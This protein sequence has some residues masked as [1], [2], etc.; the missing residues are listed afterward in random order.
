MNNKSLALAT[1]ASLF[2]FLACSKEVDKK[3][4]LEELKKQLATLNTEIKV[5]EKELGGDLITNSK[6]KPVAVA[7]LSNQVYNHYLEVVGTVESDQNIMVSSLANGSIQTILV[8]E[9]DRVEKGQVMARIDGETLKKGIDELEVQ[10]GLATEIFNRQAKLWEEKVGTE[11]QYLQAKAGK[12]SLERRLATTKEQ[13]KAYFVKAPISGVVDEVMKKEGELATA[14][15]PFCRVVSMNTYKVT[16]DVAEAYLGK[17]KK[18]DVVE[19]SFPDLDSKSS[20]RIINAASV[21]N[22]INRSFSVEVK[23]DKNL[24]G[25]RPNMITVLKINDYSN[26]KAIVVPINVVQNS[27][28]GQFVFVTDNN[29][30]VIKKKVDIGQIYNS[31]A[32][33]KTGLVEGDMLITAGFNDLVEGEKVQF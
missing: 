12:E 28:D 33:I 19:V 18:G 27:P 17:V 16:G 22:P 30:L 26:K 29:K 8:K 13:Y 20:G 25:L 32:E 14:G 21:I 10:L 7:S 23:L 1:I 2:L 24:S 3:A 6:T 11:V 4:Q 9:G 31:N 5:L 15:M